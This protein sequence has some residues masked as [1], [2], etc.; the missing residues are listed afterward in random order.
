MAAGYDS[1]TVTRTDSGVRWSFNATA[2]SGTYYFVRVECEGL[3]AVAEGQG[4]TA[5]VAVAGSVGIEDPEYRT[6][7][8]VYTVRQYVRAGYEYQWAEDGAATVT[9]TWDTAML[10]VAVNGTVK[11]CSDIRAVSGGAVRTVTGVYSVKNGTV[12]PGI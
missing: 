12:K 6:G 5:S 3:S 2:V 9:V 8:R 1:L 10:R 7:K 11:V 4:E